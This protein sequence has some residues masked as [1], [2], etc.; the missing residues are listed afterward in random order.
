MRTSLSNYIH[1]LQRCCLCCIR[2]RYI[3]GCVYLQK[4]D[5]FGF[6]PAPL[7]SMAE[8]KWWPPSEQMISIKRQKGKEAKKSN[9]I[10]YTR[11]KH[12]PL[13]LTDFFPSLV[14]EF[15]FD[16][17]RSC[18]QRLDHSAITSNHHFLQ[19]LQ[20]PTCGFKQILLIDNTCTRGLVDKE[21][22]ALLAHPQQ[23]KGCGYGEWVPWSI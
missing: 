20:S 7:L 14:G 2:W 4:N 5:Y 18:W 1:A 9:T 17:T 8:A 22:V 16:K 13:F 11:C 21:Q 6:V 10:F 19:T 23:S 15:S 12:H 3:S